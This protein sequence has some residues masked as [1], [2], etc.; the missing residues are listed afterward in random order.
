[1]A[2]EVMDAEIVEHRPRSNAERAAFCALL[3]LADLLADAPIDVASTRVIGGHM[4]E[5]HAL[6]HQL[7][8]PLYRRMTL[9]ADVGLDKVALRGLDLVERFAARGY[10][11]REGH[12]FY[13]PLPDEAGTHEAVI[14]VLVPSYT[15]RS[16]TNTMVGDILSFQTPGLAEILRQPAKRIDLRVD[17]GGREPRRGIIATADERGALLC[18][19]L[20][21][22]DR[23]RKQGAD[24][25]AFDV[26]RCLEFCRRAGVSEWPEEFGDTWTK[27]LRADFG[28][29]DADGCRA[30]ARYLGEGAT[31]TLTRTTALVASFTRAL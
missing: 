19:I 10:E 25:D 2:V 29:R 23:R 31:P 26:W 9:D 24:K 12:R 20:A 13:C 30:L 28:R 7:D 4:V 16:G 3:D 18:K 8:G 17:F 15:S 1:M 14:D 11:K 6:R 5:L 27:I 22:D 21:W